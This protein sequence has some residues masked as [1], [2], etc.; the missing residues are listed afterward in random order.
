MTYNNKQTFIFHK[1][2]MDKFYALEQTSRK[3]ALKALLDYG[4]TGSYSE[5]ADPVVHNFITRCIMPKMERDFRYYDSYVYK[6]G[7]KP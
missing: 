7:L 6:H 2:W 5:H 4:F 3:D 1:E